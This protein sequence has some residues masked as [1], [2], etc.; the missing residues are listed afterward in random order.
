[1]SSPKRS[2]NRRKFSR[3]PLDV[4]DLTSASSFSGIRDVIESHFAKPDAPGATPLVTETDP[5]RF[6]YAW[7]PSQTPVS[8]RFSADLIARLEK[9]SLDI[10]RAIT[11]RGSEIGGV[12]LGYVLSRSPF[13]V[14]VEDYEPF[15]CSFSLGPTFRLSPEEVDKLGEAVAR[16]KGASGVIAVGFFRSNTRPVCALSEDDLALFD[17]LFP[18]EHNIFALAKPFSRKPCVGAIFV[19]EQGRIRSESSYLEFPFSRAELEKTGALQPALRVVDAA[20]A[21]ES[22]PAPQPEPEPERPVPP[23]RAAEPVKPAAPP[24]RVTVQPAFRRPETPAPPPVAPPPPPPPPPKVEIKPIAESRSVVTPAPPVFRRPESPAPPPPPPPAAPPPSPVRPVVPTRPTFTPVA[25]PI[26]RPETKP[27]IVP[28]AKPEPKPAVKP[29]VERLSFPPKPLAS[30]R[31][32]EP[33]AV[34]PAKPEPKPEPRLDPRPA[35]EPEPAPKTVRPAFAGVEKPSESEPAPVP[36]EFSFHYGT[37]A[38]SQGKRWRVILAIAAVLVVAIAGYY[39]FAGKS[40]SAPTPVA[41]AP[42]KI[43]IALSVEGANSGVAIRWDGG[44]SAIAA[45]ASGQLTVRDSGTPFFFDLTA[46]DLK[47]G[48]YSYKPR[49]DDLAVRL[50]AGQAVGSTRVLGARRLK[51]PGSR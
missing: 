4:E 47:K 11:N 22:A 49:T 46:D 19:R 7:E 39:L 23:P 1:M 43:N 2:V 5:T 31:I 6:Q 50:E 14:L 29:P 12:L 27:P 30:P 17:K 18:E 20:P 3:D 28:T 42:P 51:K 38:P 34:A 13:S 26:P 16:R 32:P 15:P 8:V 44:N 35:P 9:E 10:F 21:A 37:E 36:T 33:V 48:V 41:T 40:R 24:V 45:A 25:R